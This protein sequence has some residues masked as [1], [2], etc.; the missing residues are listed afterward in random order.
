MEPGTG[1]EQDFEW[2]IVKHYKIGSV[3]VPFQSCTSSI[4]LSL[5]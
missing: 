5:I 2:K 3:P 4:Q 1:L